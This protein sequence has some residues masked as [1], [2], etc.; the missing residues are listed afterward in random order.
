MKKQSLFVSLVLLLSM[1][2]LSACGSSTTGGKSASTDPSQIVIAT[3]GTGG[4]YYPLGGGMADQVT[5][6]AGITATAQSTGA[7]AENVRLL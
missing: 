5:K 2:L 7:S 4:T 1:T 6:N 3:G